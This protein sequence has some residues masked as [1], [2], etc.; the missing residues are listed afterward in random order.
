ML[1]YRS[2]YSTY[3]TN[4]ILNSYNSG[5]VSANSNANGIVGYDNP[6]YYSGAANARTNVYYDTSV[7]SEYDQPY[8]VK[9]P[10]INH[11]YGKTSDFMLHSDAA[12]YKYDSSI[13]Y[14]KDNA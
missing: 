5:L 11:S 7:I 10:V 8:T 9:P 6:A 13:W 14:F 4:A 1:Y 3:Q 2:A 12:T